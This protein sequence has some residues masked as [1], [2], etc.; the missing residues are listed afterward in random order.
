MKWHV[1]PPLR[2]HVQV[3][4]CTTERS[5][6]DGGYTGFAWLAVAQLL[7]DLTLR[8]RRAWVSGEAED[9]VQILWSAVHRI[10]TATSF[11]IR[12]M[13]CY[14]FM[15]LRRKRPIASGIAFTGSKQSE[16]QHPMVRQRPACCV[17][18]F[19]CAY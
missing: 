17:S 4:I 11:E 19:F 15:M 5:V 1:C 7:F 12:S 3:L 10:V 8:S 9:V 16:A 18:A 6:V 2:G 13:A 14:D